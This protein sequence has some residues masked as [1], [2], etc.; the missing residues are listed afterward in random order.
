M[1]R[2]CFF[3]T[4]MESGC[5]RT[6]WSMTRH[7][8]NHVAAQRQWWQRCSSP[9]AQREYCVDKTLGP[10]SAAC[11]PDRLAAGGWTGGRHCRTAAPETTR[12]NPG[13]ASSRLTATT[14]ESESSTSATVAARTRFLNM[15]WQRAA[16]PLLGRGRE[17]QRSSRP[18]NVGRRELIGCGCRCLVEAVRRG[19]SLDFPHTPRRS[20]V[21]PAGPA[22][23][24][25]GQQTSSP[26]RRCTLRPTA[27]LLQPCQRALLW[28]A[29]IQPPL[30]QST[31][32][33]L[34]ALTTTG[35]TCTTARSSQ[36][37]LHASRTAPEALG[38]GQRLIPL[39]RALRPRATITHPHTTVPG[40]KSPPD[41]PA[42]LALI[43]CRF[44]LSLAHIR[45]L[46]PEVVERRRAGTSGNPRRQLPSKLKPDPARW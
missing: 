35:I 14:C 39:L 37:G 30:H 10:S 11:R 1:K 12:G 5:L 21:L 26:P 36:T 4:M 23:A 33:A 15:T 28:P 7:A 2:V 43:T 32:R 24:S 38:Q 16:S 27:R 6:T 18:R 31:H 41:L 40:H 29:S 9:A 13:R 8:A 34:R 22:R 25:L 45:Q 19:P 3:C 42:C 46:F 20:C 44:S 17:V